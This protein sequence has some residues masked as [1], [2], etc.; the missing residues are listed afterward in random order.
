MRSA[1]RTT[2]ARPEAAACCQTYP[3]ATLSCWQM[4][5]DVVQEILLITQSQIVLI[6][7]RPRYGVCWYN[8]PFACLVTWIMSIA[9]GRGDS[10]PHQPHHPHSQQHPHSTR[11]RGRHSTE[12]TSANTH[13]APT[14]TTSYS[15]FSSGLPRPLELPP[16][17][18]KLPPKHLYTCTVGRNRSQARYVRPI[19]A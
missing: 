1:S 18:M 4:M 7:C 6:I 3:A 16:L 15:S 12:G 8:I 13:H 9:G 14:P 11:W 5:C 10:P 2:C 17:P 19:C